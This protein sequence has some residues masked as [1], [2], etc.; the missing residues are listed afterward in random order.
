VG[1]YLGLEAL[2]PPKG[3]LRELRITETWLRLPESLRK[4][5]DAAKI[6]E[7]LRR[8]TKA[9]AE[10]VETA[11]VEIPSQSSAIADPSF[12]QRAWV[13]IRQEDRRLCLA[14]LEIL[15]E[16]PA[17]MDT[18]V[19]ELR[20]SKRSFQCFF[21]RSRI[22]DRVAKLIEAQFI[23]RVRGIHKITEHGAEALRI[24]LPL[25]GVMSK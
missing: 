21:N 11:Q 20:N 25:N 24:Y 8:R 7:H 1:D 13:G 16:K 3:A 15:S 9:E 5:S 6:I 22:Y 4:K 14:L 18:L 12:A 10:N 19:K 23:L 2:L 17:R